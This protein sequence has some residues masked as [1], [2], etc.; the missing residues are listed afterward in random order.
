MKRK[1][2]SAVLGLCLVAP[3]LTFAADKAEKSVASGSFEEKLSYS[4]GFEVGNYF[5]SAG[6]D[7]QKE[8]LIQGINDAYDGGK[9]ALTPEEMAS[10]QKQFAVKMQ[11]KQ[12]AELAAML[13]KNKEAGDAFLEKN[14]QKEGVKVTES[15]LQYE[16]LKVGDGP[17]PTSAD[18]VK[19]DYVGTLI[20]G[21]EFDSSIKR[22]EPAVFGV[23]QVIKG[24]SEAMQLM[25]VGSKYR[26]VIPSDLAYGE[27]GVAP[28]IQPNSV[29]IFEVELLGIE[30]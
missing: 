15:G 30:K 14:K 18:K 23:G 4:M 29:L 25:N 26:L 13:V 11:E 8:L 6:G 20:D 7:I 9:P 16:V 28:T 21:K 5:K 1:I 2:I 3:A 12:K 10:V 27:Q 17:K 22:G 24:W 19:V